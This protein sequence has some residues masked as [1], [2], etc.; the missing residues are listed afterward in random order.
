[1]F[2][3][4]FGADLPPVLD[5]GPY[6]AW[7]TLC[8][9]VVTGHLVDQPRVDVTSQQ[10]FMTPLPVA[11]TSRRIPVASL[12]LLFVGLRVGLSVWMWLLV[13]RVPMPLWP[14]DKLR[15]YY[16]IAAEQ[17]QILAPWQ[18]WDTL[19]YQAIAERGYAA[20]DT[21]LFV[22]PL[23]PGLMRLGSVAL[24]GSTLLAG[25][26]FS[27]AAALL[28]LFA[29]YR[30]SRYELGD[31][32]AAWRAVLYL[33][34]FPSAFFLFAAY[35]ESIFLLAA[36]MMLWHLRRTEWVRAGAW[37][38]LASL[39][40]LPGAL[41]LIPLAWEALRSIASTRKASPLLGVAL[42][43][44]GALAF[45]LY[46]W[47]R[48]GLAPWTPLLAQAERF[49]GGFTFPGV[50]LV[51]AVRNAFGG[52][53]FITDGLDILFLVGAMAMFIPV[54]RRLPRVYGIYYGTY[55]A[56]FLTRTGGTEPLVGM[57]RYVLA[58][59]PAFIILGAWGAKRWVNR[60]V[61]YVGLGG[62]LFMSASF[63]LW[64]WMG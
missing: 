42:G 9:L 15:P 21:A 18:R 2:A 28:L 3:A 34:L 29:L 58:F 63:A 44:A 45:P 25:L 23:F 1:V 24:G 7:S 22:P 64:L 60:V 54:W 13:Q 17:N 12:L 5:V 20:F 53:F 6:S 41:V 14:D 38:A 62:L 50:N 55:L 52:P 35:T 4:V 61:V 40:R 47:V 33:A 27:S 39:S 30:L 48:L 11:E 32:S 31:A 26:L 46:V 49:G 57:V 59:F 51:Q 16:G 19:H 56:L 36:V 43:G 37:A 8:H 10:Q